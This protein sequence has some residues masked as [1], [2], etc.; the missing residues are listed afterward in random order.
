MSPTWGTTGTPKL[1]RQETYYD[2]LAHAG[3]VERIDLAET[4]AT[5]L[6]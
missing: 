3:D 5:E 1:F 2:E 4:Q 6:H